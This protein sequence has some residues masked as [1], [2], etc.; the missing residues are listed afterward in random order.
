MNMSS[1]QK[2][3]GSAFPTLPLKPRKKFD[4]GAEIRAGVRRFQQSR[5]GEWC[6]IPDKTIVKQMTKDFMSRKLYVKGQ[7]FITSWTRQEILNYITVL[8]EPFE[9]ECPTGKK[10]VSTP[11]FY[12]PSCVD[13]VGQ[14][15]FKPYLLYH[16]QEREWTVRDALQEYEKC[17]TLHKT[18]EH[19]HPDGL[20]WDGGMCATVECVF[21]VYNSLLRSQSIK[22]AYK[23]LLKVLAGDKFANL[24]PAGLYAALL[25][26]I[27]RGIASS[28]SLRASSAWR[29]RFS[30]SELYTAHHT[31]MRA[32]TLS[33]LQSG[34]ICGRLIDEYLKETK[35]HRA[36]IEREK[37]LLRMA[38]HHDHTKFQRR[39]I[40]WYCWHWGIYK[41]LTEINQYRL[42][43]GC[44]YPL[45]E[46][47]EGQ[48][49]MFKAAGSQFM[50]GAVESDE[51]KEAIE[52]IKPVI[53]DAMLEASSSMKKDIQEM[54]AEE[55]K[56]I[57]SEAEDLM[58][59]FSS[60]A[61][62]IS[63]ETL[64]TASSL[65]DRLAASIDSI[66]SAFESV[67]LMASN[68]F[69]Q[70]SS[71]LNT[72]PG[73][74]SVKIT[75]SSLISI[76]K[77]YL[78][79]VNTNS[80]LLKTICALSIMDRIGILKIGV[81]YLYQL[82]DLIVPTVATEE[83]VTEACETSAPL[84]NWFS[85]SFTNMVSMFSGV[86]A[87]V[88]KGA[89][90]TSSEFWSLTDTL[91]QRL[92]NFHFIGA[93]M[94]GISRIFDYTSKI[95]IT[96]SEWISK[97]IFNRQPE[98]EVLAKKLLVWI[99]QVK[100]FST[101][102]GMNAIRLNQNMREQATK[103]H[104]EYLSLSVALRM[105]PELKF[106]LM[107]LERYKK[108]VTDIYDYL[109]RLEAASSFCP[110]MF[111]IQ[112]V[113]QPGVGKS[114]LTKTFMK[115][116][117]NTLWPDLKQ[118]S[119]YSYNPN[120]EFFDGYAGQKIFYVDDCFRMQEPK[121]LT[122][123]IG[124]ITNTP[125]IL[126]MA[127]LT[128]KG[129]QL[130]S[131]VMIS[132]TNTA[133][134]VGKDVLCMEAVHRRRHMLVETVIDPDVRDPS[135]GQF[136]MPAYLRKYRKEDLPN[137]PHLKF[138]LLRPVP[139]DS[140][141]KNVQDIGI[142]EFEE[143]QNYAA[144]LKQ[145]NV[146]VMTP[147]C[148]L[149]DPTYFFSENNRPPE[150]ISLP[151]ISW[152]YEQLVH[153]FIARYRAFRGLEQSYSTKRKYAHAEM[154]IA[155]LEAL[156]SQTE[157][158]EDPEAVILPTTSSQNKPYKLIEKWFSE[159]HHPYGTSDPLGEKIASGLTNI[160]PELADID[161]NA[162]VDDILNERR[163]T[164][165]SLEEEQDRVRLILQKNKSRRA[166][167]DVELREALRTLHITEDGK[168]RSYVP[169][170][171]HPT[172]WEGYCTDELN[173][174]WTTLKRSWEV[175]QLRDAH[176]QLLRGIEPT[177]STS[178]T[179]FLKHVWSFDN[180]FLRYIWST[181]IHIPDNDMFPQDMR[182]KKSQ[183]PIFFLQNLHKK[184]VS[185]LLDVTDFD[186]TLNEQWRLNYI[187]NK[188]SVKANGKVFQIQPD[189]AFL[190]SMS[191]QFRLLMN[192]FLALTTEQQEFLVQEAKWR[193][194]YTGFYTL[195]HVRQTT[196]NFIFSGA[197]RVVEYLLSPIH[198]LFH[199]LPMIAVWIAKACIIVAVVWLLRSIGG[200]IL[201]SENKETSKYLHR[202][203][204][205]HIKYQ[206][207][208]TASG[209]DISDASMFL[210]RNLKFV[211]FSDT[212]YSYGGQAIHTEQYLIF[213][214][215][216]IRNLKEKD[217]V[218]TIYTPG[219]DDF[220]RFVI[221]R[222]YFYVYEAGDVAI[223]WHRTLPCTRKIDHY[224]ITQEEFEK[225]EFS[226]SELLLLSRYKNNPTYEFH[227][228]VNILHRPTLTTFGK[229][230]YSLD[231]AIILEGHT[232]VGKS[233]SMALFQPPQGQRRIVGIQAW[234]IGAE[235]RPQ[236][237]LQVV[238]QEVVNLIKNSLLEQVGKTPI[239]KDNIPEEYGVVLNGAFTSC[240]MNQV[241]ASA[242]KEESVGFIGRTLFQ[243]TPIARFMDQDGKTSDRVPAA[244]SPNDTRLMHPDHPLKH[245]IGKYFR[246][247]ILGFD[248][249]LLQYVKNGVQAWIQSKLDKKSFRTLTFEEVITGTREDG[250]NPMNLSS[251]PGIP[252]IFQRKLKGKKDHFQID[253]LGMVDF[254]N[255][256]T[257]EEYCKFRNYLS[258]RRLPETRAYDFPKD[259]LRPTN[260]ALGTVD[261]PP[262]TRSVT[263]MNMFYILAWREITLDFWAAMH[264]A[265]DGTFPFAPGI[266]PEGPDWS[267]A[268]YY[269]NQHPNAVDFDVSNWDGFLPPELFYIAGDIV[270]DT[271]ALDQQ[272]S[273]ILDAILHEV[274]NSYIQYGTVIYQK[275]R[276]M[277]SGFPGTAEMNSLV[278]WI[279]I[280]SIYMILTSMPEV[281][282]HL[283]CIE[284]FRQH[285]SCLVYGD[286]I[287]VTF[288]NEVKPYF[289]GVLIA[290]T[291]RSIGY[292]VT[293]AD[294]SQD[295]VESKE[296]L[297]CSFLKSTWHHL[298]SGI[299]IRKMDKSVAYDLLYWVRAKEQPLQQFMDNVVDSLRILLGHGEHEFTQ[300]MLQV[301]TWLRKAGLSP[302]LYTYKDFERDWL[303]RYY[304]LDF[305]S[306]IL[307][308]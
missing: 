222:K 202:G 47:L 139:R 144:A 179:D 8:P 90:L 260:K 136:S 250:S 280:V 77:D 269:L 256:D 53:K 199:K 11:L 305:P 71:F 129:T 189:V 42:L 125:V 276:G 174:R 220:Q 230:N 223:C 45:A 25:H 151:C 67:R 241:V 157:D 248:P 285:V 95:Y 52:S 255:D 205:S 231:Q 182:G 244:L 22:P 78:I 158:I 168:T 50:A 102:A 175:Q 270:R 221:P 10:L 160:A 172:S 116:I 299:W 301:N 273:N 208:I 44:P 306:N 293:S 70:C 92:K 141:S 200:L 98:Q 145:A 60:R 121:H 303:Q 65:V 4:L 284:S 21:D 17:E 15:H 119:F 93:G 24:D 271:C 300:Y 163:E 131:D 14:V 176:F 40:Y 272:G 68:L 206:G 88:A 79:Y 99:V 27:I 170:N 74:S 264:R 82:W 232:I 217:I 242:P 148:K 234:M 153:N 86:V 36:C 177:G 127:N 304:S 108:Q 243:T 1:Q 237:A 181:E 128:D 219:T 198:Y 185:W 173:T 89:M 107:D 7:E 118:D 167:V 115:N 187:S 165:M 212:Q 103:L 203:P 80:K 225:T 298:F 59:Q 169:L 30:Q 75:P 282:K 135:T 308:G 56:N 38:G 262:K 180:A 246:G 55:T 3:T 76:L 247:S 137:F 268:F 110:T 249:D 201:G 142:D 227:P 210:N 126:P 239:Q 171:S 9:K 113:G 16:K 5:E 265:A 152:T 286:D 207:R 41:N 257:L 196:K 83:G 66:S 58:S 35:L 307:E 191:E 13:T 94:L 37:H 114:F 97:H 133:W 104:P 28:C 190:F 258:S 287:I 254:I 156:F 120:L 183:F 72:M 194:Q 275:Q 259:E 213:N 19:H 112:F 184:G 233:G 109:V 188:I 292:P 290:E 278:H 291:Y 54:L 279:L 296:L 218:V 240:E 229:A 147:G 29:K 289:N 64:S 20:G 101:E 32:K 91:S 87:C 277:V 146:K 31:F 122:T 211:V 204:Q 140:S 253:E 73:M 224:F 100:Y 209:G 96:L 2:P 261:S 123:L 18:K 161:F 63:E 51:F 226:S 252:F 130:T 62:S 39:M 302:I 295:I 294:K 235:I 34:F 149:D 216:F 33:E 43:S 267:A 263:C 215:H 266:N 49:T 23:T 288:S 228:F 48:E 166:T 26:I 214:A 134:P 12:V 143:L 84:F 57:K 281:P 111:H 178:L 81:K 236:I 138:N 117:Q 85:S 155:E 195:S 154:A 61:E 274:M 193:N 192:E 238:T 186:I 251:S 297:A 159:V 245:S 69:D 162:I 283:N 197:L 150:G 6:H 132:S 46:T 106:M 124:L 105:K 164:G